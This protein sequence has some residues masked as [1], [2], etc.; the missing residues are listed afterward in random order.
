VIWRQGD[1]TA[2]LVGLGIGDGGADKVV[3][4]ARSVSG[5]LSSK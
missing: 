3:A 1:I 2:Q 5:R 4:L